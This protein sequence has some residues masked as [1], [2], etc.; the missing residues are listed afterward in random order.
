MADQHDFTYSDAKLRT[1]AFPIGGIGTGCFSLSGHGE[2][3]DWEI[4]HRPNKLS[5]LPNTFFSI[6]TKTADGKSNARVLKKYPD[7]PFIGDVG[8]RN[9]YGFGFGARRETGS[10]LKHMRDA[11]FRGEYPFAWIDFEEPSLPVTVSMMAY[12]PVIPLN[13]DD[14]ALPAGIFEFTVTNPGS[15]AVDISIGASLF[16]AVGYRGHGAMTYVEHGEFKGTGDR[17]Y[18]RFEWDDNLA[19]IYMGSQVYTPDVPLGG[20]M[21]LATT[22]KDISYQT[23]WYRGAWFDSMQYFWDEFSAT[24]RLQDRIYD[25]PSPKNTSDTGALALHAHLEPGQTVKIPVFIAWY[26]PNFIKYWT[27]SYA[28]NPNPESWRVPYAESLC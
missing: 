24:G 5:L 21:A 7:A 15:S 12:N 9:F 11:H 18:N 17:N 8:G 1:I 13:V 25:E 4:F 3:Q 22:W 2:L 6:W 20:S 27:D 26:F 23:A 16:N 28:P 19:A 10:G 14:S